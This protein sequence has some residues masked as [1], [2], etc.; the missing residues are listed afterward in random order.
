[1]PSFSINMAQF[2][3]ALSWQNACLNEN[4]SDTLKLKCS[5]KTWSFRIRRIG[6]TAADVS[7][8]Y[9]A[10]TKHRYPDTRQPGSYLFERSDKAV[11][12]DLTSINNGC[13]LYYSSLLLR[14][15]KSTTLSQTLRTDDTTT[16]QFLRGYNP[17]GDDIRI[18]RVN[19]YIA[20][21]IAAGDSQSGTLFF[22][23]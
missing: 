9:A 18:T 20:H 5:R 8:M 1:M 12:P 3:G 2:C 22:N 7:G 23:K 10:Y 4:T 16:P 11:S 17:S 15:L 14:I 21:G 6:N 13:T 19:K